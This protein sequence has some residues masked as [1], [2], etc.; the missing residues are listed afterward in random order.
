MKRCDELLK[1]SREHHGSLSMAQKMAR[2]AKDGDE[3]ALK[4][5]I[6]TVTHYFDTELD[7]HFKHEEETIFSL[8]LSDYQ[9]HTEIANQLLSEHELIR[10][11]VPNLT[12]SNAA[13]ELGRFAALLKTHTRVEEREL[14]PLIEDLFTQEQL[15]KMLNYSF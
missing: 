6:K 3:E 13:K 10:D 8:I 7:A 1:L 4:T 15:N 5:A 11:L 2:I 9:A 12:Y 14:F